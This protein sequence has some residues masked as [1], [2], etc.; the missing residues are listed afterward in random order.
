MILCASASNRFRRL[1]ACI[2]I[3]AFVQ[4]TTQSAQVSAKTQAVPST[5]IT[6]DVP[7]GFEVSKQFGGFINPNSGA[8]VVIV[9]LPAPAFADFKSADFAKKMASNGF[10]NVKPGKLKFP[11]EYIYITAEQATQAGAFS[12]FLLI[13]ADDKGTAMLTVNVLK[14]DVTSGKSKVAEIEAMLSTARLAS[15]SAKPLPAPFKLD[16]LGPFKEAG[17]LAGAYLYSLDGNRTPDKPD[18]G[19]PVF[20]VAPATNKVET[21]DL[22]VTSKALLA[23]M[24]DI[25][26]GNIKQQGT[27]TIAGLEGYEIELEAPR[28]PAGPNA[29]AYQV[30]VRVVDGSY[31][32][33]VGTSNAGQGA[34][35]MPEFRKM[36]ASFMAVP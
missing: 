11:G 30:M 32:R 24:F 18:P 12:K 4:L 9:E 28:K 1:G 35:L 5:R 25:E 22:E 3:A 2:A 33:M 10:A 17:S 21:P 14:S 26:A 15:V 27:V 34:S 29:V 19:R 7:D 31:V 23:S 36:A 16:Y 20:I 8:S 13:F 6:L